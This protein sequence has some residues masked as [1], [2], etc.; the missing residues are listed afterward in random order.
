MTPQQIL[1]YYSNLLIIQYNSLPKASQ[2][3]QALCNCSVCDEFFLDIQNCFDLTTAQ[4]DQLTIIGNIVGVPRNI[5]G[6]DLV[7]T[8]FTFTNFSGI[9]D[10]VGFNTWANGTPDPDK[11]AS[12]YSTAIYTPTDFEMLALIQLKII[13]NTFFT[14]L[15]Q[16]IPPL[17]EIFGNAITLT[18]NFNTSI[19]YTFANPYHNVGS[20]AAFL[21]NICPKTMG[22]AVTYENV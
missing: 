4:G 19:S 5:Y 18:D 21:G 16:I 14:S 3:I 1:T 6:L 10:S 20:V 8:F 22:V 11:I 15:G 12:W 9:P 17:Y 2:T 7:D 13:A